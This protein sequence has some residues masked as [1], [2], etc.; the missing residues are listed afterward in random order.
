MVRTKRDWLR[1][2][3]EK[4]SCVCIENG[5]AH[6]CCLVC[7]NQKPP[8]WCPYRFA[9]WGKWKKSELMFISHIIH[10]DLLLLL[11]PSG[12]WAGVLVNVFSMAQHQTE[13]MR[14]TT[15]RNSKQCDRRL[16]L[17]VPSRNTRTRGHPHS[18]EHLWTYCGVSISTNIAKNISARIESLEQK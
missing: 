11:L 18:I 9:G 8:Y 17:C 12:C 6:T 14:R 1:S 3:K 5:T 4:V 15:I 16:W 13:L 10:M 2:T 7:W